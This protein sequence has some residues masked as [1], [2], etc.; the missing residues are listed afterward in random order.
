[1]TILPKK[2]VS[3]EKNE[4]ETQ[5]LPPHP[6]HHASHTHSTHPPGPVETRHERVPH[7]PR[8]R[9]SPPRWGVTPPIDDSGQ[10]EDYENH[11]S[12]TTS[13]HNK[14]RHRS[15]PHR[16][17]R[18]HRTHSS[19]LG[20]AAAAATLGAAPPVASTSTTEDVDMVELEGQS[21]SGQNSEDEY[22][23]PA[24][25]EQD[26][27]ELEQ[28]FAK[29]AKEKRGLLIKKMQNDGAC[30]F[31][32]VAD[33]VYGDQEMHDVVRKLSLDYMAKNKDHFSQYI[34]EDF[35]RYIDRKRKH[36]CH[37]NH[38][39]MQA[40]SELYNRPVEVYQY[41]IEPINIFHG[42]YKTEDTEPIRISY[43]RGVH[44]NSLTNPF[45][46][47]VGVGLGLP[48][49]QPGLAEKTQMRDAAKAS[50]DFHIEK[51]MLEDKLRETDW[52][53]TQEALEEQVARE[54]YLQ[55]LRDNENRA[56]KSRTA[57]AAC[58][59]AAEAHCHLEPFSPARSPESRPLRSPRSRSQ[60]ASTQNS[61]N[62][63]D[64]LLDLEQPKSP[65]PAEMQTSVPGLSEWDEDDILAQ[66]IAQS[67]QEYM[68]ILKKQVKDTADSS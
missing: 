48:G 25:S 31:R 24:Y 64:P 42:A 52:E 6:P 26:Y 7:V 41:G 60:N 14:R 9:T 56:K 30:L 34:T 45:K 47:T 1:M 5:E 39:E 67:Q 3:K 28:W 18:K 46:A 62:R 63:I 17:V 11:E 68:D 12:A 59:S 38:I 16:N 40:I 53:L 27:E 22:D 61:P 32:A 57:S 51:T 50:E 19:A 58:S 36:H 21:Q 37:G 23:F 13:S 4:K 29:V 8:S 35:T 44:Y 49:F 10:F 54:S 15:S 2:K 33:Q 65:N 43:H 55:W 20:S 66:V